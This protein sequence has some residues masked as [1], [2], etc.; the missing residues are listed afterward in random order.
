MKKL[1]T[2]E[3]IQK[4]K[5]VHSDK[6][7]YSKVVY[8]TAKNNVTIICEIHG[9]FMQTPDNH[10]RGKQG[11]PKCKC[12]TLKNIMLSTQEDFILKAQQVHENLYDYSLVEYTDS[13]NKVNIICSKHGMFE[14][15]ANDHLQGKGCPKCY[16][17][18]GED[19][20]R[21]WLKAHDINF[22]EQK[23]FSDCKFKRSLPFDFFLPEHNICIEYDG[24]QHFVPH[25][26][27]S[28][29]STITM[30]TNLARVQMLDSI[31]TNF[32]KMNNIILLRISGSVSRIENFLK[33][34]LWKS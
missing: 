32:C 24:I 23:R 15:I 20:I 9:E 14:Q 7:D 21:D 1:T 31:K 34:L 22:V 16:S 27:N 17:S 10:I 33:V 18:K 19:K 13:R 5:N 3:F 8:T 6:F 29:K 2:Q 30:N 11:C 26:F 12:N 28:D 4:A 25:S